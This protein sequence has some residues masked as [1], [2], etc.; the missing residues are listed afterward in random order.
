MKTQSTSD[1]QARLADDAS[2]IAANIETYLNNHTREGAH[3]YMH[4]MAARRETWHPLHMNN[5][6]S[7]S[8]E[9]GQF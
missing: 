4:N 7:E 1:Q 3:A 9:A 8:G 2:K 5:E 6:A